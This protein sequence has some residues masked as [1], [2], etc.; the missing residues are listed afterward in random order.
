MNICTFFPGSENK[1]LREI[2]P[3]FIAHV[4]LLKFYYNFFSSWFIMRIEFLM[5]YSIEEDPV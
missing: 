3:S 4:A 2:I 1:T 5:I